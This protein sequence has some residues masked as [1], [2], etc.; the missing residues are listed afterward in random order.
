MNTRTAHPNRASSGATEI[1]LIHIAKQALGL[2]EDTYRALVAR[3]GAGATS[4]T[5]LSAAQRRA[6]LTHLK[7]SG[8]KLRPNAGKVGSAWQREPQMRKLR[9]MWYELSE[10]GHVD[11]PA[12]GAACNAAIEAWAKRQLSTHTP[13]LDALR[14][15]SGAQMAKLIEELKAWG[16]RVGAEI[17]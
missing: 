15:A 9:A 1:K 17:K 5:Q 11:R 16:L 6:L 12:D 8:F 10:G 7:D 4:S 13:P 14:F 2:D 3:F